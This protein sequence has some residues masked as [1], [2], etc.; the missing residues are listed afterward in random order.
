MGESGMERRSVE[1]HSGSGDGALRETHVLA[2][3]LQCFDFAEE[4]EGLRRER[5]YQE[6]DRNAKT[7]V[8]S[9][10]FRVVLVVLKA[11]A[12]FDEDDPRGHVSMLVRQGGV[13][14]AVGDERT[15][16]GT[17]QIAAISAGHA[18]SAVADQESVVVLHFSWPG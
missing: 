1:H 2:A 7:L 18:R 8:K 14:L 4:T 3:P 13:S 11:G 6:H 12:R 10:A 16:V 17:G 5:P 15:K 9:D